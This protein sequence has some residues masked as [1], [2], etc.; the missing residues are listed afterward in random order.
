[1]SGRTSGNLASMTRQKIRTLCVALRGVG[2]LTCRS[3]LTSGRS[4]LMSLE[5]MLGGVLCS[6]PEPGSVLCTV[7]IHTTSLYLGQVQ[8]HVLDPMLGGCCAARQSPALYSA[9]YFVHVT[10]PQQALTSG[11]SVFMSLEPM[12]GGV[13]CSAPEPWSV[14]QP[15]KETAALRSSLCGDAA[16]A[17][18]AQVTQCTSEFASDF[19]LWIL[20]G[21]DVNTGA[22]RVTA[23]E[24]Q[25]RA[26]T[27]A[28]WPA[29]MQHAHCPLSTEWPSMLIMQCTAARSMCASSAHTHDATMQPCRRPPPCHHVACCWHLILWTGCQDVGR[30][31]SV[32]PPEQHKAATH[33]HSSSAACS[34]KLFMCRASAG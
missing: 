29:W 24:S 6:A 19:A 25:S 28:A 12:L 10:S 20:G 14:I 21:R 17:K 33:Q 32:S 31:A 18:Q 9:L 22:V 1:M 30:H 3:G 11:R 27:R 34:M 7:S 8:V 23:V 5:P 4:V 15:S 16:S 2:G 13:L 26:G